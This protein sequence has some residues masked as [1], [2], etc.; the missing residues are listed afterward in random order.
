MAEILTISVPSEAKKIFD[1]LKKQ[2][3]NTSF[4]KSL[5][6]IV[7]DYLRNKS[8]PI[9]KPSTSLSLQSNIED[10]KKEINEMSVEDFVKLQKKHANTNII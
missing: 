2:N 6:L 9:L 3:T 4:S 1:E 8:S 5:R 10:W 7:E